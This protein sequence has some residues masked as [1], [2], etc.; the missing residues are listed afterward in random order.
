MNAILH[1]CIERQDFAN[2]KSME[3]PCKMEL[4][5]KLALMGVE[6]G[7]GGFLDAMS[8]GTLTGLEAIDLGLQASALWLDYEACCGRYH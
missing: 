6:I 8:G 3:T 2:T 7:V 1:E 5:A 4:G